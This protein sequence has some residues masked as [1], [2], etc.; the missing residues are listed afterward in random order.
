MRFTR[1]SLLAVAALRCKH[2]AL[3]LHFYQ[4]LVLVAQVAPS[5]AHSRRPTVGDSVVLTPD[6]ASHAD[7]GEGPL[8]PGE[9]GVV[10]KDDG[11]DKPFHI[12]A[13]GRAWWYKAEAV[14]LATAQG[15]PAVPLSAS[16]LVFIPQHAHGLALSDSGRR[17]RASCDLCRAR[18]PVRY[19]AP[20]D[21]DCVCASPA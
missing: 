11:S 7:A 17:G 19:C 15:V 10:E 21:F 5:V 18:D 1:V 14:M 13:N 4:A 6:Y 20:C 12:R 16:P 9:T 8:R 2:C 3:S